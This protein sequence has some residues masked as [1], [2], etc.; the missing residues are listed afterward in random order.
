VFAEVGREYDDIEQEAIYADAL[1]LDMVRRPARYD[2]I[3]APNLFGDV[4]SDLAAALV[5]GLG[6]APSASLHPGRPG[7]FEPVHGSAPDI[8]GTDRAN[9]LA[10]L[11]TAALLL[12][13]LG[14][15]AQAQ[16]VEDAVRVVI[17]EGLTTPDLGGTLG[18]A[19]VGAAVRERV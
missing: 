5:G 13:Q 1:A 9:P 11:L 19:A 16:R 10:A 15:A 17:A 18:T 8:A 3:V 6:L 4:L 14:H 7:L 2:V 12:E